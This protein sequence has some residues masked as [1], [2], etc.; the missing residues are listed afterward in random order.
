[1]VFATK[2]RGRTVGIMLCE[3]SADGD[4]YGMGIGIGIVGHRGL[5]DL[6]SGGS[7]AEMATVFPVC[8][9][10]SDGPGRPAIQGGSAK[11]TPG[12]ASHLCLDVARPA[13]RGVCD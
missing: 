12:V 9:A 3:E 7:P 5:V 8:G 6:R 2:S 11:S 4:I 10:A 13:L 1:M